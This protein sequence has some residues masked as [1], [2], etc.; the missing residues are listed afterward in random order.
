MASRLNKPEV[1]ACHDL[2][3]PTSG[4]SRPLP[5]TAECCISCNNATPIARTRSP[6][7]RRAAAIPTEPTGPRPVAALEKSEVRVHDRQP[8]ERGTRLA[9][10]T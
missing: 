2:G 3:T 4:K 9:A 5:D 7:A 10:I 8:L 1:I 6:D